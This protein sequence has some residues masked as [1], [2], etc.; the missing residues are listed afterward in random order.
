MSESEWRQ[1]DDY[2]WQGPAGWTICRVWASGGY[3]HELW[4]TRGDNGR[5]VGAGKTLAAAVAL[6]EK[7]PKG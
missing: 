2:Y 1:V 6:F 3:Q 7:Q 4:H 5:L